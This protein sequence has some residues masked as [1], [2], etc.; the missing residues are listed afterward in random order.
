MVATMEGGSGKGNCTF[1]RFAIAAG[2]GVIRAASELAGCWSAQLHVSN[3]REEAGARRFKF[4]RN[5]M[6][7]LQKL[8]HRERIAVRSWFLVIA[9]YTFY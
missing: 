8:L 2:G 5:S 6:Q 9:L 7:M 3:D 1:A 4:P